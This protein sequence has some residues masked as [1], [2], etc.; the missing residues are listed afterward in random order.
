MHEA[1]EIS[2]ALGY[3]GAALP[4]AE[5]TH[6]GLTGRW[7]GQVGAA[8]DGKGEAQPVCLRAGAVHGVVFLDKREVG[9]AFNLGVFCFSHPAQ[10]RSQFR[11]H[12]QSSQAA[13]PRWDALGSLRLGALGL[14]PQGPRTP[15][16]CRPRAALGPCAAGDAHAPAPS[17]ARAA[18]AVSGRPAAH[19]PRPV[20]PPAARARAAGAQQRRRT[21]PRRAAG[22]RAPQSSGRSS[23]RCLTRAPRPPSSF[24]CR[25]PQLLLQSER[26]W[27][28]RRRPTHPPLL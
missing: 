21:C 24:P 16:V 18:A 26:C 9:R 17:A 10:P 20:L 3:A 27:R 5:H 7:T 13:S 28:Y 6:A 23:C 25:D 11:L 22:T 14:P 12:S 15:R 1:S 8:R 2:V 19:R 4:R